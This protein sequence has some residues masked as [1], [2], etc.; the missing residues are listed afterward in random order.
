MKKY[1]VT[2]RATVTKTYEVE[3][4]NEELAVQEAHHYFTVMPDNSEERYSED[5]INVVCDDI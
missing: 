3:A 5:C 4:E 1:S 2:I